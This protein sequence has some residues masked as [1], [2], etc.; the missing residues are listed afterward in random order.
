M[1]HP[2]GLDELAVAGR[3]RWRCSASGVKGN[4]LPAADIDTMASGPYED[5][6]SEGADIDQTAMSC[7]R[8]VNEEKDKSV[9]SSR[10]SEQGGRGD[11]KEKTNV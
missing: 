4:L 10:S 7:L 5:R 3:T 11:E 1:T 2:S 6:T 9:K 8:G